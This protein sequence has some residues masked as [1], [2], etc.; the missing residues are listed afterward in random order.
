MHHV[1]KS[2]H[3][4]ICNDYFFYNLFSVR[5]K[6]TNLLSFNGNSETLKLIL[7]AQNL[8]PSVFILSYKCFV[9]G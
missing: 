9:I 4:K 6:Y 1:L 5:E 3:K 8:I 7:T 2:C